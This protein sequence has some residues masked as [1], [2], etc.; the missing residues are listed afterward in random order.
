MVRTSAPD[1]K[2]IAMTSQLATA[3]A[4]AQS[5]IPIIDI[6]ALLVADDPAAMAAAAG[7][8]GRICET[9]GFFAVTGHGVPRE[10]I[11]DLSRQA[12]AFFDLPHE[13][14]MKIKRPRP[15]QNRGYIATGDETLARL[16]GRETPPDMKEL[17]AIGPYRV[18]DDAYHTA[19]NAYPSFAA[20]LWPDGAPDLEPAMTAYWDA[21]ERLAKAIAGGFAVALGLPSDYFA[22]KLDRNTSQLRV[23]HYPVPQTPPVPGQL[24]A[25]EHSDLG[26]MTILTAD[27]DRG[28][29]QVKRRG[30]GWIDVP[31]ID[32]A[33][34]VNLGDLMMRWTNDRWVSTP[35][36]VVNPGGIGD[37]SSRRLSIGY[38]FNPNYDTEI[39]C[40]PGCQSPQAPAKYETLTVHDY[41]TSRFAR[42][43]GR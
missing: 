19:P 28:G 41:R 18:P 3:A 13:E 29:L 36:R 1:Q 6:S 23:M 15:E 14:K 26:M 22:D 25:G 4:A 37:P 43:A 5:E 10:I 11:A 21:V 33:F 8:L 31:V 7:Q 27:N 17:F 2:E 32:G 16:G 20:N 12:Y 34:V 9:I 42:T 40:L 24:R 39:A 35:H 38:F 30:G